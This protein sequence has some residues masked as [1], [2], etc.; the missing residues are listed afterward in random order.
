MAALGAAPIISSGLSAVAK[1][2]TIRSAWGPD[3][4][5]NTADLTS[6]P[7]SPWLPILKPAVILDGGIVGQQ[8]IAPAGMPNPEAWKTNLTL[9][10]LGVVGAAV[11]FGSVV[12]LAG[13]RYEQ[14]RRR[15]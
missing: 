6:G 3:Y 10:G 15:S 13:V 8:V 2:I 7:P 5:L 12:F 4:T 14:R 9:L 1:Q 11:A